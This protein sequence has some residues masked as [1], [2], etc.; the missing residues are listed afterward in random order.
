MSVVVVWIMC[1]AGWGVVLAGL[2][3]GLRGPGRGPALFA[4][5]VTP[6]GVVLT[7]ALIGYGSLYA[8]I[9]LAAEW[10]SLAVVTGFRPARLVA[11]GG[12]RRAAAWL[13]L[14]AAVTYVTGRLVLG[15]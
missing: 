3:R 6:A 2:R 12:L 1:A 11:G 8:T 4:H 13:L 9:A 7:F 14:T 10:W 15:R 5:T